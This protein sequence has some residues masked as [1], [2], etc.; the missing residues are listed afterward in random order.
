MNNL[1]EEGDACGMARAAKTVD[2]ATLLDGRKLTPFNYLL[3]MLSWLVTLFDGLDMMMM[4]FTAP[5]MQDELQLTDIEIG[6]AFSAGT[7]GMVVGGL[8][9]TYVGDRIGRRPT[10]IMC[11]FA[12]GILTFLT[13]FATN[14]PALLTLRFL[15]GLAIGGA[16]P[17]A[18]ALNVEF[19]PP[20]LRATVI[21][22]IMMGF[23][24]GSAAAAPLT[25]MIAPFHGWEGV[26]FAG[27]IGSV[28][29]ALAIAIFL[30]ESPRFLAS[31]GIK[32]ELI[33]ATIKRLDK[34]ID[35][36]ADDQFILA[37]EGKHKRNFRFSDLFVGN[38]RL[39]TPIIWIGYGASALGIFFKSAF[40]PLVLERMDVAR[41]TA[42]NVSAIGALLGAV[43]GVV[44]MRFS[45]RYG[46]KFA[47][48]CTLLI[49]PMAVGIG[50]EWIPRAMLL[51]TIVVQ[52]M[53][54]GGCHAAI[55]SQLALYYPSAIRASAGG[56]ASAVG[57][58]GGI[59]GPLIGGAILASGIPAVRTYALAAIC[60]FIL[61]LSILVINMLLK[62]PERPAPEAAGTAAA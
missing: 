57:K 11:T 23:S 33:V 22:F 44:I 58:I 20:K 31:K 28:V 6:N 26:Y 53:L 38:L 10:I 46:L 9:F 62:R 50:M 36:Q 27:G 32:P 34:S 41:E 48:A 45:A 51:P 37:D 43:A 7:V 2:L 3:I 19:V 30:P 29:C 42:A 49:V 40:G 17:L 55:I 8:I 61:F 60:P 24:L 15:D 39:L 14:Y 54:V 13:G 1:R 5:Y 21:A 47:A 25:N 12:F 4:S 59:V 56:W 52:S 35:V 16:L 18:W